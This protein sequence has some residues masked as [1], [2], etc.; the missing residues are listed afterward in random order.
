MPGTPGTLKLPP[1]QLRGRRGTLKLSPGHAERRN[2]TNVQ[3]CAGENRGLSIW[4]FSNAQLTGEF[5]QLIYE[6]YTYDDPTVV[7]H[8]SQIN[9]S[10]DALGRVSTKQTTLSTTTDIGPPQVYIERQTYDGVGRVFQ[11]FDASGGNRGVRQVYGSNGH[12]VEIREA[13]EEAQ[14]Q[15][16]WSL[17]AIDARD[18]VTHAR[19]GNGIELHATYEAATGRLRALLDSDGRTAAQER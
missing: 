2:V 9:Y 17:L 16:Y 14:S 6:S 19:L 12:L 10:Y 15:A 18:Q 5:G 11:S 7:G 4:Q 1:G 3:T 13:S 8:Q